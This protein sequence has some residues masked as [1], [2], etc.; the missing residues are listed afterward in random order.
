MNKEELIKKINETT[1]IKEKINLHGKLINLIKR[2]INE[3]K[4][5][6]LKMQLSSQ[7]YEELKVHKQLI[8]DIKK[9][10]DEV[11]PLNERVALTIKEISA[12]IQIFMNKH[13][14]IN[15]VKSAGVSTVFSTLIAVAINVGLSVATGGLSSIALI[16]SIIPTASY[17][18]L[19]NILRLPFQKTSYV[20]LIEKLESKDEDSKKASEFLKEQIVNN[21]DYIEAAKRK[22]NTTTLD[23][24][25]DAS[26]KLIAELDKIVDKAYNE[27]CKF[28]FTNELVS[29]M[30]ELRQ[31]YEQ[32]KRD[33]ISDKCEMS[34]QEFIDL[35]KKSLR[36]D[37]VIFLRENYYKETGKEALK[38]FTTNTATMYAAR[39]ILSAFFPQFKFEAIADMMTPLLLSLINSTVNIS[40][41][42]DKIKLKEAKYV[43]QI[44]M[45]KN[46]KEVDRLTK[47]NDL[48][49]A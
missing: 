41:I 16:S 30:K 2:E 35:E 24:Q 27:E 40:S 44:I 11:I 31:L 22:A 49:M 6:L 21:K 38:N 45:F 8:K 33:Y 29:I 7:L 13:D 37:R 34:K 42:R 23:E 14:V 25:I 3:A 17:I 32:K 9:S 1:S 26:E 19:S 39:L 36:L 10:K 15:I 5:Q 4:N 46:R 20:E 28:L 12:T 47:S 43:N 18:A 48:V